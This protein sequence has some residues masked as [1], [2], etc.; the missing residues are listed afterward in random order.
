M[1]TIDQLQ[2][3]E[4]PPAKD[5][6]PNHWAT[7][8]VNSQEAGCRETVFEMSYTVSLNFSHS[9]WS[10]LI[11]ISLRSSSERVAIDPT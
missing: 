4:S 3:R 2:V 5:R 11:S 8:P 6:R 9:N 1:S 7:P 10:N